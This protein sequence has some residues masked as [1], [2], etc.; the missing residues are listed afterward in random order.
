MSTQRF[1]MHPAD[2]TS[3]VKNPFIGVLGRKRLGKTT[4]ARWITQCVCEAQGVNRFLAMCGNE[5]N[6]REW[7]TVIHPLFVQIAD[8]NKLEEI[9]KKQEKLIRKDTELYLARGGK[10][11]DYEVPLRLRIWV[12]FDDVGYKKRFCWSEL[13]NEF[14][15]NHR[16]LGIAIVFLCQYFNQLPP[17]VRDQLDYIVMLNTSND[18]NIKKVY[19]TYVGASVVGKRKS[20]SMLLQAATPGPGKALWIDNGATKQT[21]EASGKLFYLEVPWPVDYHVVGTPDMLH[22][23]DRHY[24]KYLTDRLP[25]IVDKDAEAPPQR[26]AHRHIPRQVY[27]PRYDGQVQTERQM[28][29]SYYP[30]R[31]RQ[32]QRSSYEE[33]DDDDEFPSPRRRPQDPPLYQHRRPR[34]GVQ[35]LNDFAQ[36]RHIVAGKPGGDQIVIRRVGHRPSRLSRS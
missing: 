23:A 7:S 16:H 11:I 22:S 3:L 19:S 36:A 33:E 2:L 24:T 12:V 31:G 17:G 5:D 34:K 9:K 18:D 1:D 4:V 15:C 25:T 35:D 27:E 8:I 21:G 26:H 10:A 28:A 6:M 13:V 29:E 20:F 14:A 30:Q 32:H